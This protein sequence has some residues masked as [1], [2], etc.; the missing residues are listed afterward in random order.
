MATEALPGV[1]SLPRL[2]GRVGVGVLRST[3]TCPRT[4]TQPSPAGG[5]GLLR[6][7]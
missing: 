4:P 3:H 5:G 1:F 2:R 7:A 6:Q